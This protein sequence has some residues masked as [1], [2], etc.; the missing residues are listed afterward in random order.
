MN[1]HP[2]NSLIAVFV[3]ALL[4]YG[5]WTMEGPLQNYVAVGSFLYFSATLAPAIG[6]D[7]VHARRAV[8]LRLVCWVFFVIALFINVLFALLP[9]GATLY[10][11]GSAV[12]FLAFVF[13][14]NGLY[15][16]RQ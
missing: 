11:I 4:S 12:T 6:V 15:G 13:I 14:A 9:I 7:F 10:I 1:V 2:I 5:L 3:S 16:T 8:N